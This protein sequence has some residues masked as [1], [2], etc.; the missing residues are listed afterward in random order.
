MPPHT[1]NVQV[2]DSNGKIYDNRVIVVEMSGFFIYSKE[3]GDWESL[4]KYKDW[5]EV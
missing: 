2:R 4:S 3:S 5:M 1:T